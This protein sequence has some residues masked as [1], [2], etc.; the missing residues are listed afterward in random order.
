MIK[1]LR[2]L[3]RNLWT[4]QPHHALNG[5]YGPFHATAHSYKGDRSVS[6]QLARIPVKDTDRYSG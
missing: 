4:A 5:R 1:A 6:P 2:R 3:A